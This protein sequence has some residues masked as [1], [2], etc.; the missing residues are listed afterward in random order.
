MLD[1]KQKLEWVNSLVPPLIDPT[2][3]E[4]IEDFK[5][6]RKARYAYIQTIKKVIGYNKRL[7]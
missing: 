2:K 6:V 4:K 3:F 5:I 1:D 7:Y